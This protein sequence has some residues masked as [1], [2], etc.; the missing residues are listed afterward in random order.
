[1]KS[2]CPQLTHVGAHH[3]MQFPANVHRRCATRPVGKGII[4][5]IKLEKGVEESPDYCQAAGY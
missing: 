1:M 2:L 3:D 5:I 4:E